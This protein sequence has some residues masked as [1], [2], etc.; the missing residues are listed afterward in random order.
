MSRQTDRSIDLAGNRFTSSTVKLK[1]YFESRLLPLV[2]SAFFVSLVLTGLTGSPASAQARGSISRNQLNAPAAIRTVTNTNDSG[3]GTL[4]AALNAANAGDTIQFSLAANSIITVATELTVTQAITINGATATNLSVSGNNATRVFS[5][6]AP[7][8]FIS[9]TIMRGNALDSGGGLYSQGA[10]TLTAM[11]IMSNTSTA[12]GGGIYAG[13]TVLLNGGLFQNNQCSGGT[14]YGGGLYAY[15]TLDLIDTQFISN[16]TTT[17]GGGA[18]FVSTANVTAATFIRNTASTYGGGAYFA[19][20]ANV[21]AATFISNLANNSGGG[22]FFDGGTD[23]TATTF[24]RNTAGSYGGGGYWTGVAIIATTIFTGNSTGTGGGGAFFTGAA[25]M[26]ATTFFSNSTANYGGGAYFSSKANVLAT[27]FIKNRS[28]Y[29]GGG[30]SFFSTADIS[31]TNFTGNTAG[32]YGGGARFVSMANV[33]AT[34]FTSNTAGLKGG[35]LTA[36]STLALTDTVLTGNTATQGGGGLYH[37]FA[38]D[39]RIVN[40]IFARNAATSLVGEALYL[41]S[42]GVVQILYSTIASPTLS[43]GSAIYVTNGTVGITDTIVSRYSAGISQI[44]GLVFEDYNLFF[45][46][47][48]GGGA[49][50]KSGDPRFVDPASDDYHLKVGS[51]ATGFAIDI[52]VNTDR[53]GNARPGANGFD[54]GAYQYLGELLKIYMPMV[55]KSH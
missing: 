15:S 47:T 5:L 33:V 42:P 8:T 16:T 6:T 40:T 2:L 52:G 19:S 55:L 4:R 30:V 10:L 51:A 34:T 54:I 31:A 35:G 53:D 43:S 38:G 32:N 24:T 11:Q 18:Y 25:N 9:F 39:G 49:H 27:N 50:D 26:T 23:M 41:A 44:A 22:A 20:T 28:G 13:D 3:V 17:N 12:N 48:L 45:Q 21:A 36:N 14:C 29:A 1:Q 46:S 7:A 37:Q